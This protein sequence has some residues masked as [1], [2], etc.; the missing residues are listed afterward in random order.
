MNLQ[1]NIQRIKE[2]MGLTEGLHDTS[3]E[4][5]EGNKITL[6]D[7]LSATED[8]PVEKI[9]LEWIKPHLLSWGGDEEEVKKIEKAD[10]Q[11]PILIF[12]NDNG[13]FIS[14]I[15]GH[16]RAQ[17]AVRQKLDSIEGKLIPISF[18]PKKF[19]KVFKHLQ[20]TDEIGEEKESGEK[21]IKCVNCK[22]KFTQTIHKGKKSLPICPNC[23]THNDVMKGLNES[24]SPVEYLKYIIDKNKDFTKRGYPGADSFKRY[25][26]IKAFQKYVD[27]IYKYTK[28][29]A[30]LEGVEGMTVLT[31]WADASGVNFNKPNHRGT[32]TDWTVRITPKLSNQQI[33]SEYKFNKEYEE[34]KEKFKQISQSTGLDITTPI[35][36]EGVKD[37]KVIFDFLPISRDN[38]MD[39][40]S[41][42]DGRQEQTESEITERCWKGYTQ[43]G[44]KTMFGKR[45]PNCV[46]KK[47]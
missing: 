24:F 6:V 46:K 39:D 22:K 23:G 1:E 35:D 28:K 37:N 4:N 40:M 29:R 45:Y 13:E 10:L 38:F 5:E 44:M 25:Q 9:P 18:L 32:R 41:D 47:K 2:V 16:H 30:P 15:D 20:K 43:K 7:L 14:I 42:S 31:V 11:Y 21:F 17:K 8:M 34:F 3:W 19:K 12:V 33:E 26:W 36:R 27:L